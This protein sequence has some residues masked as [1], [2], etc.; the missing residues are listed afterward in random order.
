MAIRVRLTLLYATVMAVIVAIFAVAVYV[1]LSSTLLNEVDRTLLDAAARVSADI[2]GRKDPAEAVGTGLIELPETGFPAERAIYLQVVRGNGSVA[3]RSRSL[4]N[5]RLPL[6]TEI[7]AVNMQGRVAVKTLVLAEGARLRVYSSPIVVAQEVI[8][9]VQ[10]GYPLHDVD[11]VLRHLL[12]RLAVGA[13]LVLVVAV[14]AG[15]WLSW[16]VLRPIDR[17]TH[18]VAQI[19][20]APD[21]KQ[22]L[23]PSKVMDEVGRLV[24]V[25]NALLDQ[26]A[27]LIEA[28]QRL[29]ADVSHELRTPLTT[30]RGN[31]N[32]LRRGAAD[33]PQERTVTLDAIDVE[34]NRM[35]RLVADLLLLAQADAGIQLE[36]Q[37]VE[38]DTLL[39]QVYRQA[40]TLAAVTFPGSER[41]TI[42]LGHEDQAIVQG[43]PD[44]L[45]QLLLNLIDNALKYT[46]RGGTITL[47][48]FRETGWVR[49][50][51]MDT[52]VGIPPHVLPHIFERFYRAPQ[53]R[54]KGVGLGL[55][56]ARWIAEAHR[57]R[58]EVESEL[59]RGTTFT[60]WLPDVGGVC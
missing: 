6:D 59:G 35:S 44:R 12:T 55:A 49:I 30:I 2:S 11:A 47:S 15:W 42:R 13:V 57:G 45:R 39:L 32:L 36:R 9:A 34:V 27:R 46:P 22:R 18:A 17:I 31:V 14:A 48:L 38:M 25:F 23:P 28:Q 33:D 1:H 50:V 16:L 43:D 58:L 40:Q 54:R 29:G 8:G 53:Q 24:S 4:H 10:A 7:L 56:I 60:L 52:G 5:Q 51:V 21:L 20:G 41:V 37:P 19:A 3:A 26:L